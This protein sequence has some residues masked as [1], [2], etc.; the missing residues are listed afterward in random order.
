MDFL[1]RNSRNH[2]A[3][4]AGHY[5]RGQSTCQARV[6]VLS[7]EKIP[8][9]L[10]AF[11]NNTVDSQ[12]DLVQWIRG[13]LTS[14]DRRSTLAWVRTASET[15]VLFSAEVNSVFSTVCSGDFVSG[16]Y[17]KRHLSTPVLTYQTS[18]H[19]AKDQMKCEGDVISGHLSRFEAL[20]LRKIFSF[21]NPPYVHTLSTF[22][23]VLCVFGCPLLGSSLLIS[24]FFEPPVPFKTLLTNFHTRFDVYPLLQIFVT[25]LSANVIPRT[26]MLHLLLG[27]ELLIWSVA[28]ENVS[29]DMSKR[30]WVP[31][32]AWLNTAGTCYGHCGTYIVAP[33]NLRQFNYTRSPPPP[34]PNRWRTEIF[35]IITNLN[36]GGK[37][38][39]S[40]FFW[41]GKCPGL[42][43]L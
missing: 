11:P 16:S 7:S 25:H 10:S 31:E 13:E 3:S 2:N 4:Y 23:S 12:F 27:N 29:W 17:W 41:D 43:L 14:C 36:W 40:L 42:L 1:T 28:H 33:C 9:T 35:V 19:C 34:P 26:R 38:F 6:R 5:H 15:C 37:A 32:F 39:S 18:L 22:V 8:V 30:A 21:P 20:S 24:P